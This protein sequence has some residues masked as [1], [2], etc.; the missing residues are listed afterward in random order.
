MEI[1][2][3]H[4][5]KLLVVGG[6]GFIGSNIVKRALQ[7]GYETFSIS[8]KNLID[9][10]KLKRVTYITADITNTESLI[11]HLN[12]F[13]FDYI[14]NCSGYIN[15]DDYSG[16]GREV[17]EVHFNGVKNLVDYLDKK[18]IK[19]FVQI[20]S[21]DEYGDNLAPQYETQ[22]ESPFSM[23]SLSKVASTYF[24]Q[25]LY[26]TQRFPAVILRPFLI[27][28]PH[29]GD[30]RFIT[31]I[32]KGCLNNKNFPVSQGAQLRDFLFIDDFVD[33]VF[34]IL[35]KENIM[36]EIINISSGVPVS[37][38][39]VITF[40]SDIIKS[41]RPE[42]GKIKYR[43]GENMRLYGDITKAKKLLGWKPKIDLQTGLRK[44]INSIN[45]NI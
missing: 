5:Y 17:F 23:Y 2:T 4:N 43:Q 34:I 10:K 19:K 26:K 40:I 20:G 25:T 36:G 22:K 29:Q 1:N 27:Y 31:K 32:I 44:T 15:H 3:D 24:L 16:K 33:A 39:K 38:K 42:F 21:S 9:E 7:L 45:K 28:G 18:K 30:D 35:K 14:I 41:G 11:S 37:I 6:T 12:K 13:S 8:K